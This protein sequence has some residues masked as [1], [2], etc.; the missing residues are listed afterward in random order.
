MKNIFKETKEGIKIFLNKCKKMLE[1]GNFNDIDTICCQGYL[2]DEISLSLCHKSN[3]EFKGA[4][5]FKSSSFEGRKYDEQIME[6][7]ME[8]EIKRENI[9]EYLKCLIVD[10]QHLSDCIDG[11]LYMKTKKRKEYQRETCRDFLKSILPWL[12]AAFPYIIK[13]IETIK[14]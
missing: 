13:I 12:L 10:Y 5:A 9:E 11:Y 7:N 14:L 3:S 6:P 8:E 2:P 4:I 1:T